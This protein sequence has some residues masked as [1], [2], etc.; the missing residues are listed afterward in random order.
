MKNIRNLKSSKYYSSKYPINILIQIYF[1]VFKLYFEVFKKYN[2]TKL[3]PSTEN[4]LLFLSKMQYSVF[5]LKNFKHY[6]VLGYTGCATKHDS[7]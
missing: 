5:K 4:G 3:I 7:W 6:A 2:Q 1:I